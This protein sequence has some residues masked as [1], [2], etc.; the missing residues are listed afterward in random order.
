[1][2]LCEFPDGIQ[3]SSLVMK[4]ISLPRYYSS[5]ATEFSWVT[6]D[7][8]D[9]ALLNIGMNIYLGMRTI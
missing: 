9:V 3:F 2:M 7:I 8:D 4:P 6:F 1:M 5:V